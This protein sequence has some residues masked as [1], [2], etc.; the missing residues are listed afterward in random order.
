MTKK[1]L[2]MLFISLFGVISVFT[3]CTKETTYSDDMTKI[4]IDNKVEVHDDAYLMNYMDLKNEA[5]IIVQLI[6]MDE[7][8][9]KTSEVTYNSNGEATG[10]ISMRNAKIVKVYKGENVAAEDN[11]TLSVN[12]GISDDGIFYSQYYSKPLQQGNTYVMFLKKSGDKYTYCKYGR[13]NFNLTKFIADRECNQLT[14]QFLLDYEVE[15]KT[16]LSERIVGLRVTGMM[17]NNPEGY[18]PKE[19]IKTQYADIA[20]QRVITEDKNDYYYIIYEE[21]REESGLYAQLTNMD[22]AKLIPVFE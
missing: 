1:I 16:E 6:V 14:C 17:I 20:V 21:N 12:E 13:G 7:L 9:N 18:E 3:G 19:V 10:V 8:S 2:V 15:Q 22:G 11:I 4:Y 5:D